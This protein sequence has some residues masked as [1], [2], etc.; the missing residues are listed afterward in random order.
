[1][2]LAESEFRKVSVSRM[3]RLQRRLRAVILAAAWVLTVHT[4]S[5]ASQEDS[6][7]RT[8]AAGQQATLDR[9]YRQA[10]RVLRNGLK[11]YPSDNRLRLELGQ[12]YLLNGEDSRS[13]RIFREVL[14]IDPQNR[15]AKLELAK[16]LGLRGQYRASDQFYRELIGSNGADEAAAI[17]LASNLLHE[18]QP[19]EARTVVLEA[20]VFHPDSLRLQEFQDRIEDG[21]MGG[22]EPERKSA[23]DVVSMETDYFNDSAGNH[24]WRFEQRLDLSVRPGLTSYGMFE[25]YLQHSRDDSFEAVETFA[26]Q[27]RWKARDWLVGSASGGTVRFNNHDVH[28]LYDVSLAL[29][30]ARSVVLGGSFQRVPI[31]PNAEASEHRLTAQGWEAFGSWTGEHWR[32]R[33]RGSREHYSDKNI[34]NRATVDAEREWRFR[35]MSLET[36]YRFRHYA[37]DLPDLAHGYFDPST[38]Q[39]HLGVAGL[40]FHPAK[41]YRA[42]ILARGGAEAAGSGGSFSPAWEVNVRNEVLLG[43]WSLQLDYSRYHLLQDTG[44]F[45]AEAG[46]FTVA[47]HF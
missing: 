46:Q 15:L 40:R 18:R 6:I 27:M 39:S 29:Q 17:G 24:S 4:L 30:P 2:L 43:N 3:G 35:G 11:N 37:F 12:A 36:G 9:H 7:Q 23:P 45:R 16:T 32:L 31:I 42:E 21:Y 1:L 8:L 47:Y 22:E 44:A 26:G 5:F 25:Q 33:A 34:A 14:R 13:M 10:I 20:L 19:V 41:K 38:Y 28:A